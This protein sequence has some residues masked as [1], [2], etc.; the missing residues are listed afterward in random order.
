[1]HHA[2]VSELDKSCRHCHVG[3]AHIDVLTHMAT[4]HVNVSLPPPCSTCIQPFPAP[5]C[6]NRPGPG[7]C[8]KCCPQ[9]IL[10]QYAATRS[11][12]FPPPFS[13]L[14]GHVCIVMSI[15][16][17]PL[18]PCWTCCAVRPPPCACPLQC[19]CP[20]GVGPAVRSNADL[21]HTAAPA[22]PWTR[23]VRAAWCRLLATAF[24]GA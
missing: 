23:P 4:T 8:C 17:V 2:T 24:N 5:L 10:C 9:Y 1:M 22:A 13:R 3:G 21:A 6:K 12:P 15:A 11:N 18:L 19:V 20:A 16:L 7:H 14:Q